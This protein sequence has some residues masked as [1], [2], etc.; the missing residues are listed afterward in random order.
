VSNGSIHPFWSPSCR[1]PYDPVSVPLTRAI[2]KLL[3]D[4]RFKRDGLS[5][6]DMRENRALQFQVGFTSQPP[7][8]VHRISC[9][10]PW[11]QG[12]LKPVLLTLPLAS[13]SA[14]RRRRCFCTPSWR[15]CPV[16]A[17]RPFA[18]AAIKGS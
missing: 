11:L 4:Q 14:D 3:S 1:R 17:Q 8:L 10:P 7:A 13:I 18:L 9:A 15:S 16:H 2:Q 12:G 5:V 6:D